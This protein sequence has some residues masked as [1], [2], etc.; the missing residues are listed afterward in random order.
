MEAIVGGYIETTKLLIYNGAAVNTKNSD[1]DIAL[2][3]QLVWVMMKLQDFFLD[4][5]ADYGFER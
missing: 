1:G 4:K 2:I 5:G 3:W